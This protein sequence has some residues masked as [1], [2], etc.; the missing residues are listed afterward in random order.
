MRKMRLTAVVMAGILAVG[1]LAGCGSDEN[2][3]ADGA[4]ASSAT[5]TPTPTPSVAPETALQ[6]MNDAIAQVSS[7]HVVG[8]WR[9]DQ[10]GTMRNAD[11][12]GTVDGSNVYAMVTEDDRSAEIV[13]VDGTTYVRGNEAYWTANG[14]T[15]EQYEFIKDKWVKVGAEDSERLGKSTAPSALIDL[16]MADLDT[17][18]VNRASVGSTEDGA[19][20]W[21]FSDGHNTEFVIDPDTKLPISMT[22][23]A[24]TLTFDRWDDVPVHEPPAAEETVDGTGG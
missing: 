17:S 18:T 21:V 5:P 9:I 24:S 12:L 20:T 10:E 13:V 3:S 16:V 11:I 19:E 6:Q 4:S 15:S 22:D 2:G 1:G 8:S 14:I 7:V 23:G